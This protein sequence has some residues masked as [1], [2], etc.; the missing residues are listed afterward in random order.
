MHIM[1]AFLLQKRTISCIIYI[2]IHG[3]ACFMHSL[4][5]SGIST[6]GARLL[7]PTHL[8]GIWSMIRRRGYP[9][10]YSPQ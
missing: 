3:L 6:R 1:F 2:N 5:Y 9:L 4:P 7:I 10:K 8:R